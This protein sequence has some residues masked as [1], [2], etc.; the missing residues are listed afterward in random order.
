MSKTSVEKYQG[1]ASLIQ[2]I[3]TDSVAKVRMLASAQSILFNL[4]KEQ[5]N[6]LIVTHHH[7]QIRMHSLQQQLQPNVCLETIS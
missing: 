6:V 7:G 5:T 1:I 2:G 4:A 3:V